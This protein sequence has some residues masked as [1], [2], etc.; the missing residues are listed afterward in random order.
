MLQVIGLF[1]N[2]DEMPSHCFALFVAYAES[3]NEIKSIVE[4]EFIKL[5]R[6]LNSDSD[7]VQKHFHE[8]LWLMEGVRIQFQQLEELS[9]LK[10]IVVCVKVL[11]EPLDHICIFEEHT[12]I[13]QES[14]IV[15]DGFAFHDIKSIVDIFS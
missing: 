1:E 7:S 5:I 14:A 3:F 13:L 6:L 2:F 8:V 12:D 15:Q 11:V 4:C 9:E 10:N